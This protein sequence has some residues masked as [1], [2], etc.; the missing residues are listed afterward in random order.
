MYGTVAKDSLETM[1]DAGKM[2][3]KQLPVM[4]PVKVDLE[5]FAKFVEEHL[6]RSLFLKKVAVSEQLF[7]KKQYLR[8]EEKKQSFINEGSLNVCLR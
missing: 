4:F 1:N 6:C 5:A 8:I 2:V 3:Q 7:L